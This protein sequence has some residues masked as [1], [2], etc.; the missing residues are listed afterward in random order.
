MYR[1]Y[2]D[3]FVGLKKRSFFTP[4]ITYFDTFPLKTKKAVTLS[5]WKEVYKMVVNKKHLTEEGFNKVRNLKKSSDV[6]DED[7]I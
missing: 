5:N 1:Y 6:T 3:T 4:I 7:F 2:C